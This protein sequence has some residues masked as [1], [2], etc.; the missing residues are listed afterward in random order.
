MTYEAVLGNTGIKVILQGPS[1][2]KS[3]INFHEVT[4]RPIS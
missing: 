1:E 4:L 3:C 2:K